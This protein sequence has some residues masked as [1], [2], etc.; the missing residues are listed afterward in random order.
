MKKTISINLNSFM[1]HIDEDA[2]QIL[3]VYLDKLAAHFGNNEEG[4]EIIRDIEARIS[5]LFAEKLTTAK[6]VINTADVEEVIAVLGYIDDIIDSDEDESSKKEESEPSDKKAGKKLFRDDDSKVLAGVCSGLAAYTGV[7]VVLWR[8][9]FLI[10]LFIP[11]NIS[12]FAYI[13]LWIA[14]PVA[15]T[16]AQKLEM[17]GEKVNLENIEKTVKDEYETLKSNLKN[18]NTGKFSDTIEKIWEAFLSAFRILVKVM[19][20]IVGAAFIIIGLALSA[21]VFVGM[22]STGSE[23]IF[24]NES[25][26]SFLWLPSVL[27]IITNSEIAWL[28][29]VSILVLFMIPVIALIYGGITMLFKLRG[30]KFLSAGLL[31]IWILSIIM[32]V[33][34]SINI[35]RSYQ[36]VAFNTETEEIP[37]DSSFVYT[38]ALLDDDSTFDKTYRFEKDKH[39]KK[40]VQ[41]HSINDFHYFLQSHFIQ[42]E[43]DKIKIKP[44]L[45]FTKSEKNQPELEFRYY[46]R[47]SNTQEAQ[48]NL[49]LVSYNYNITDS[50]VEFPPFYHIN[51]P[52]WRA[53]ELRIIVKIPIGSSIF[54][55][56]SLANLLSGEDITGK[57]KGGNLAGQV[58]YITKEGLVLKE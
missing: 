51:S 9:I 41:I 14:V 43:S 33:F 46:A 4:R 6:Q 36:T 5:E 12:I 52:R 47:G 31:I 29:S 10:F 18:M 15:K 32:T 7:S 21:A 44:T 23:N 28:L 49:A 3:H 25:W 57:Y 42:I 1:F 17:K 16:T 54:I 48:D 26:I 19:T 24:Y 30:S 27:E 11:G 53:Q 13:I 35:G 20:P 8:V 58:W 55:D 45:Q 39:G 37:V 38:F 50:L 22:I 56:E 2:Y 40:T 34:L